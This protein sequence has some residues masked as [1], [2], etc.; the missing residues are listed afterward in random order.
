[1]DVWL[2]ALGHL[3]RD[4]GPHFLDSGFGGTT[5][6]E[7]P[8]GDTAAKHSDPDVGTP[9]PGWSLGHFSGFFA[10]SPPI[11]GFTR[12][13]QGFCKDLYKGVQRG[14]RLFCQTLGY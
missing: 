12:V 6:T 1:M 11:L 13:L 14:P 8:Q 4:I 2:F 9:A 10:E 7:E 5:A 3:Q